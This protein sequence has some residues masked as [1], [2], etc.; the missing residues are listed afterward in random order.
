MPSI[1]DNAWSADL[2]SL[3]NIM[4]EPVIV[5]N[6]EVQAVVDPVEQTNELVVGGKTSLASYQIHMS[7]AT[8]AI[9][10]PAK[11]T[12]CQ[13]QGIRGRVVSI[14]YLGGAGI[15]LNISAENPRRERIF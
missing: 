7:A 11:G 12:I 3:D 5:G 13:W 9:C 4:A 15:R 6:F 14:T 2:E 1:F 8:Q 10:T